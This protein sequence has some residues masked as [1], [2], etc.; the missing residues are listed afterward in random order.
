MRGTTVL[1]SFDSEQLCSNPVI[2]Y[3]GLSKLIIIYIIAIL[4]LAIFGMCI[5]IIPSN[6]SYVLL[7]FINGL[8][9]SSFF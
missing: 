6:K 9:K 5:V 8:S 3:R 7:H 4:H 1:K 2:K